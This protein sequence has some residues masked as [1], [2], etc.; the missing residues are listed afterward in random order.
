MKKVLDI[1]MC[2]IPVQVWSDGS[3]ETWISFRDYMKALSTL[4]DRG[5]QHMEKAYQLI[6]EA[7]S[8]AV[9]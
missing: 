1:D 8:H 3:G 6:K 7:Q 9:S 2:D 4:L 5:S